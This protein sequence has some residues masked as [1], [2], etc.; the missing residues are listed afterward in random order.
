MRRAAKRDD[1]EALI[2]TALQS[3]GWTVVRVSDT[4]VPDLLCAKDGKV[5]LLEVKAMDGTLTK[6]QT[7]TFTL[8]AKAGVLVQVVRSPQEALELFGAYLST[9]L[10]KCYLATDG[11][12][13]CTKCW[14]PENGLH[15]PKCPNRTRLKAKPAVQSA[16]R[17]AKKVEE[18]M[19]KQYVRVY[20]RDL[21][22][23]QENELPAGTEKVIFKGPNT[24]LTTEGLV[25]RDNH[26]VTIDLRPSR[27][28]EG[29]LQ[30][31]PGMRM[32]PK[33]MQDAINARRGGKLPTKPDGA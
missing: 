18:A 21:N 27:G 20:D 22:L 11:S 28:V 6:A 13:L 24:V 3:A 2:V 9:A 33:F 17:A 10:G 29:E 31:V 4:G 5:T 15:A 19:P 14:L 30:P 12:F 23:V 8:L 1:N 16:H 32:A 7:E 25:Y 26:G